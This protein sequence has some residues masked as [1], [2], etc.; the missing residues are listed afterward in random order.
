MSSAN[1]AANPASLDGT[2][3][4]EVH[5]WN[6]GARLLAC[7]VDPTGKH[8]FTA[9][10][11]RTVQRWDVVSGAKTVL[12]GHDNWVSDLACS[13]DGKTL[14]SVSYDGRLIFWDAL[15]E[16]PAPQRTID[17]HRGWVRAVAL[18]SDGKWIATG[19]NDKVVKIWSTEDG[20][21]VR[22][23][24]GHAHFIFSLLFR[25]GS[26]DLVSGD[27]LGKIHH[28]DAAQGTLVRQFDASE[29]HF[30]I[31]D[32][33]HYGGILG[34][35]FSPDGKT[36]IANGLH[37]VSNALANGQQGVAL[38]YDW[39]QGSLV[40]KHESIKEERGAIVWGALFHPSGQLI[41]GLAE[42]LA[43]W[44]PDEADLYHVLETKSPIYALDL[45]PN[46]VDLFTAHFDGH[47]RV[48]KLARG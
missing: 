40:R 18:S 34:L 17:A 41:A 33:S 35:A 46:Q 28:W 3:V 37:K 29:I 32:W 2:A 13:L 10:T 11:D 5:D 31:G 42:Y 9:S 43:F 20:S 36:L 12:T 23:M 24:A 6:H 1:V 27:L 4:H 14:Y 39:E 16:A 38:A 7:R 22:E 25:P 44:K 45:H 47:L 19:G 26:T 48:M 8:V 15:A 30:E 21:L